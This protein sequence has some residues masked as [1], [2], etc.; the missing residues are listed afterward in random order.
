MHRWNGPSSNSRALQPKANTAKIGSL[1]R[2]HERDKE[3]SILPE[4][5]EGSYPGKLCVPPARERLLLRLC[6]VVHGFPFILLRLELVTQALECLG[7]KFRGAERSRGRAG[8]RR[9]LFLSLGRLV[10]W[11]LRSAAEAKPT[12]QKQAD[13][14]HER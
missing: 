12:D 7:C 9:H 13:R 10:C 11:R 6:G 4:G 2:H 14:D 5:A 3:G 1:L 8:G